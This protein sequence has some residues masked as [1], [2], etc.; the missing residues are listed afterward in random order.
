MLSVDTQ[1]RRGAEGRGGGQSAMLKDR[2]KGE[3]SIGQVVPPGGKLYVGAQRPG[4][5]GGRSNSKVTYQGQRS[6]QV[7]KLHRSRYPRRELTYV[8]RT[9]VCCT[10]CRSH[11]I[12]PNTML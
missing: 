4:S 9:H 2:R 12:S 5:S 10:V 7:C 6:C 8:V 3:M 11:N 1:A